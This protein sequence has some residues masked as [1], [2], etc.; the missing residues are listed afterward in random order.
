[1]DSASIHSFS[2]NVPFK[3][4]I[5]I[6][7]YI[8]MFITFLG[9]YPLLLT[10]QIRKRKS[11]ILGFSV[12]FASVGF[13]SGCFIKETEQQ[14]QQNT[15]TSFIFNT[16]AILLLCLVL[17][18]LLL[19]AW[20]SK[21]IGHVP[22]IQTV[23]TKCFK[24]VP[25]WVDLAL[26][27]F[28]LMV[29]FGYLMLAAVVFTESCIQENSTAQCLMPVA[30]GTGFLL[31][32]TL[33][34]LHLL[35]IIKLPRPS[36]PEYYEGVI[37]TFWGFI[38]LLFADRGTDAA[39]MDLGTPILGSEWRA[40][41]LGLLWF[42]GGLFSISLSVQTWIPALRERNV[43]NS[44]IVCLTGR[45]IVSGIKQLEDDYATQVHTMLGYI[46][47]IG[48]TARTAQIVFRKSPVDNLPHRMFQQNTD[49]TNAMDIDEDE[50]P[51]QGSKKQQIKCKHQL[52]FASVTLVAGL[53][54]SLMSICGGILFMGA[55][56]GWINYMRYYIQDPSTYVNLTVAVAFLWSAYAFGLCTIYKNLKAK[57]AIHQYEYMELENNAS[58]STDLPLTRNYDDESREW[59]MPMSAPKNINN[60]NT[61]HNASAIM[62]ATSSPPT[63]LVLASS[64]G[65]MS[66]ISDFISSPTPQLHK[67]LSEADTSNSTAEKTIR[68]SEYRAK[69]RSLL[70][71]SSV[72]VVNNSKRAR[73]SSLFGVGG[74]LPD[75]I[76]QFPK[77][78]PVADASFRRSWL[79]S[80]SSSSAG[81]YFSECNMESSAPNSPPP[82]EQR[83]YSSV[84]FTLP[85]E[86][87]YH[88][89]AQIRESSY[90]EYTNSPFDYTT[91]DANRRSV[92]KTESGK[93]K[94]RRL[95]L[96]YNNSNEIVISNSSG[97]DRGQF[98]RWSPHPQPSSSTTDNSSAN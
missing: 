45:A 39:L 54:A 44:I 92:H 16:F 85:Q 49:T 71:Q 6:T 87:A 13:I 88:Q 33:V 47:I 15:W 35:A 14:R 22:I 64:P 62:A 73:S 67:P 41:N 65:K 27:W 38:S 50:E 19:I 72:P 36:T 56:S 3:Q 55:H 37:L 24:N 53:L 58:S 5:V 82:L 94:E 2:P 9:C 63:D 74:I 23:L 48:A 80:T 66:D 79:S 26:G 90:I 34:L 86:D 59:S 76:V 18:H 89:Q 96:H 98:Q 83:P 75:E 68:P 57:N 40:I 29:A 95:M 10:R 28:N 46:L 31:Y 60:C 11:H 69:R 61:Q 84:S 51:D 70:I 97:T 93:R 25:K 20:R 7:H 52:I 77:T 21:L 30:M 32:G 78:P 91:D 17:T 4:P 8:S 81:G 1:M 42:A 43:I 12:F